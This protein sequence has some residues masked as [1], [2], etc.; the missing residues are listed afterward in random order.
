MVGFAY[1][2]GLGTHK[3]LGEWGAAAVQV[4]GKENN[5]D[6]SGIVGELSPGDLGTENQQ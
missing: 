1:H 4:F 2:M 6:E 3:I 5:P